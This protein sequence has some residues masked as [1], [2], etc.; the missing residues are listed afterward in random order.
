[1]RTGHLFSLALMPMVAT[2][3]PLGAEEPAPPAL[4]WVYIGT[5]A[6]GADAGVYLLAFDA[7]TGALELRGRV[8]EAEKSS[9]L[10]V[11]PSKPVLYATHEAEDG[12]VGAFRID[13]NTGELTPLGRRSAHGSITCHVAVAPSGRHVAAAN[14]IGGTLALLPLD[15]TGDFAGD[16][17]FVQH[18]GQGPNSARQDASHPHSVTF[19]P[20][21]RFLLGADLGVDKVYVYRYRSDSDGWT[22][23]EPPF[24]A[25]AP[26]AGPRHVAFHPSG[27]FVYVVNELDS[28]VTACAYDAEAGRIEP[29]HTVTT[30][31]EDFTGENLTAE[32]R[33]HPSGRFVYASNRGHDSLA[34]YAVDLETGRLQALGPTLTG[35]KVP[36]NFNIDPSGRFLLAANQESGNV[37]VFRIDADSGSLEATSAS[38]EVP[39]PM[40]VTFVAR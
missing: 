32:I 31:P 18:E 16:G 11:H 40:C 14:Y 34:A 10:A 33:V 21:G 26:G 7:S 20:T 37:V 1:M 29:L 12:S 8:A 38:V 5:G 24:V 22:P 36:R 23:H 3:A 13:R 35:G 2:A 9:F 4:L 17:T 19:D 39:A 25:L 30:L 28:T 6:T 15:E 27:R